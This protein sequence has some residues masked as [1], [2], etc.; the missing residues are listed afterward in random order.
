MLSEH[1]SIASM[2]PEKSNASIFSGGFKDTRVK[3][4]VQAASIVK[5]LSGVF[6]LS[7]GLD[8][9]II[10]WYTDSVMRKILGYIL[11]ILGVLFILHLLSLYWLFTVLF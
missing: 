5:V 11:M 2:P 1:I 6:F 9:R 4:T 10:V 8:K 7:K 3:D